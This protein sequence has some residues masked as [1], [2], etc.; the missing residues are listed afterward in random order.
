MAYV[1]VTQAN[2]RTPQAITDTQSRVFLS[3]V[4]AYAPYGEGPAPVAPEVSPV[5]LLRF[6]DGNQTIDV[7]GEESG[8]AYISKPYKPRTPNIRVAETK[9]PEGGITFSD[10]AYDAVEE[11]VDL[12]LVGTPSAIR[13]WVR[14]LEA[15]F[16]QA[17]EAEARETF[18]PVFVYYDPVEAPQGA[19][20]SPVYWGRVEILEGGA[21]WWANGVVEVTVEWKRGYY[22]EREVPIYVQAAENNMS[23]ADQSPYYTQVFNANDSQG[24][25]NWIQIPADTIQG[26]LP[27]PL[28]VEYYVEQYGIP[29][30]EFR[31]IFWTGLA[32]GRGLDPNAMVLE[33]EDVYYWWD[34][35]ATETGNTYYSD[36]TYMGLSLVVPEERNVATWRIDNTYLEKLAGG[37]Y[38]V[39]MICDSTED[40]LSDMWYRLTLAHSASGY[41]NDIYRSDLIRHGIEITDDGTFVYNVTDL[42]VLQLPPYLG[43]EANPEAETPLVH[44]PLYLTLSAYTPGSRDTYSINLDALYLFPADG[45]RRWVLPY[46]VGVQNG[47]TII[48]E[49]TNMKYK[50]GSGISGAVYARG[51]QQYLWPRKAHTFYQLCLDRHGYYYPN[52]PAEIRLSYRPRRLSV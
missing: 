26:S 10:Y 17:V 33:A 7:M 22:W 39:L 9:L 52:Y 3:W 23:A 36:D 27:T 32:R 40:D 24:R 51:T 1:V 34:R 30:Y 8:V 5:P 20:R 11:S 2:L 45:F 18:A 48:D 46:P 29:D 49:Q 44:F 38:H 35:N 4:V 15:L 16:A 50:W 14:D 19:Y 41:W 25:E 43:R 6:G 28:L 13:E 12:L 31:R 47:V 21:K 42:G 37:F